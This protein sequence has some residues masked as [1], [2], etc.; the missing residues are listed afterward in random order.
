MGKVE[1]ERRR[2]W[3]KKTTLR[4]YASQP[5]NEKIWKSSKNI[6][7]NHRQISVVW[8]QSNYYSVYSATNLTQKQHENICNELHTNISRLN[9]YLFLDCDRRQTSA[10]S[11]DE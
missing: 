5:K 11:I 6:F 2:R 4:G 3:K 10:I 1:K 9:K 8:T 7:Q